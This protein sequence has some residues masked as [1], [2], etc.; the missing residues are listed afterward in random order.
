[1]LLVSLK[2]K[3]CFPLNAL[4][5]F[6]KSKDY[7]AWEDFLA[8]LSYEFSVSQEEGLIFLLIKE[9]G[10]P[11]QT[12]LS[13]DSLPLLQEGFLDVEIHRLSDFKNLHGLF[14]HSEYHTVTIH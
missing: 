14:K 13:L 8:N 10:D 9:C 5:G 6:L 11:E 12:R 2:V 3:Y 1:M 4:Y 7:Q